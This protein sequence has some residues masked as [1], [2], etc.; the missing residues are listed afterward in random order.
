M[1]RLL[2]VLLLTACQSDSL[3]LYSVA[4]GSPTLSDGCYFPDTS[5][6]PSQADDSS[7]ERTRSTWA[8]FEGPEER[9]LLDI[10]DAVLEGSLADK[11]WSFV[12]ETV[13]IEYTMPDGTG[14]K[15]TSTVKRT[16]DM[17]DD[18]GAV[19]G[20]LVTTI[21]FVCEGA[22]CVTGIPDCVTTAPFIGSRVDGVEIDM[23]LA[24]L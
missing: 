12:G 9:Y 2:P 24:T 20:S 10:G 3:L 11:T 4:L 6:P 19:T 1:S 5:P 15:Y 17:T 13:D 22:T 21:R 16:I 18:R 14:D 8:L 23:N 7:T